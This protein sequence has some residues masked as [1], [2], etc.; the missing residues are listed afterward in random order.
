[1]HDVK[2]LYVKKIEKKS[3]YIHSRFFSVFHNSSTIK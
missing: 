3:H 2:D 1:M